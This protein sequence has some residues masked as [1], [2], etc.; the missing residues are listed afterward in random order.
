M[1]AAAN[2]AAGHHV[3]KLYESETS[4]ALSIA[5]FFA[6]GLRRGDPVVMISA[7]HRFDLVTRHLRSAGL[8]LAIDVVHNI[9]FMD[10]EAAVP[11]ILNTAAPDLVHVQRVFDDLLTTIRRNRQHTT[12]W[13]Y[14][15][16]VD[17]L[18]KQHKHAAA[19]RLEQLANS[20][21][22][23]HDPLAM[24]CGY[25]V[26]NFDDYEHANQLSSVCRQHTH[27][28]PAYGFTDRL[29]ERTALE[30]V[31]ML[32]QRARTSGW[33]REREREPKSLARETV[34]RTCTIYLIDDEESVRR[35]LARLLAQLMLPVRTYASAEEFLAQSDAT[36]RGCLI[37]DVHLAGMKGPELQSLLGAARWSLPV[38]AISGSL[39][40]QVES[41]ALR[42]GA[43]TFLCKPLDGTTLV[44]AIRRAL[45][46][47]D[48]SEKN[49]TMR[50]TGSV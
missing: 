27:V 9:Q 26:E 4:L 8:G 12:I 29:C 35:S 47:I 19:I 22:S 1:G 14:G 5:T 44:G 11:R 3:M 16:T 7:P 33:A 2:F 34:D 38:I 49:L 6:R 24:L 30:P 46:G 43:Q 31:A 15:D 37:V 50:A 23:K 48:E 42:R 20:L 45:A 36:A 39:D 40:P 25:A 41:E 18:C 28:I 21:C 13:V 10:A 17:L 32:Q